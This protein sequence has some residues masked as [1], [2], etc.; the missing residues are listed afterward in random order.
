M[1][2]TYATVVPGIF[3]GVTTADQRPFLAMMC[4]TRR[5][6]S[7]VFGPAMGTGSYFCASAEAT[8]SSRHAA[9]RKE[10]GVIVITSK[11]P[12]RW[13]H[14]GNAL[15]FRLPG[16]SPTVHACMHPS[17]DNVLAPRRWR[18][19]PLHVWR[20]PGLQAAVKHGDAPQL[21]GHPPA[22]A[23]RKHLP[24]AFFGGLGR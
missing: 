20:A 9:R 8:S 7:W 3:L 22:A 11:M 5:G 23:K 4:V 19:R 18:G 2:R 13:D 16:G 10:V 12:L 24:G 15:I 14:V 6:L 21:V 1:R 17:R